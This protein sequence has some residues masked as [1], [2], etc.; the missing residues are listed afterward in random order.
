MEH[1]GRS[2]E[3]GTDAPMHEDDKIISAARV[4][5]R[6]NIRSVMLTVL[7]LLAII[8]TLYFARPLLM[9]IALAVLLSLVLMPVVRFL[10]RKLRLPDVVSSGLIVIGLAAVTIGG[11]YLLHRPAVNWLR[12]LP[13]GF[14]RMEDEIRELRR[15]VEELHQA[16]EQVDAAAN[17]SDGSALE[18]KV[19]QPGS[20]DMLIDGLQGL[21]IGG[22]MVG[23]YVFFLLASG[24]MFLLKLV[25]VIPKFEDKKLAVTIVHEIQED[26]ASYVF[27]ITLINIALGVTVGGVL[28]A[29]GVPNAGLWGVMATVLNYVPYLGAAVGVMVVGTVAMLRFDTVAEV[30]TPPICYLVLT[31]VEATFITPLILGKRLTL[32]PVVLF[33]CVVFWGWLWGIPGALIAVP[34]TVALAIMCTHIKQLQPVAEFISR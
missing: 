16:A 32:N 5:G 1:G 17:V 2:E 9:P 20:V 13:Q 29:L 23:A 30:L 28:Y 19:K 24:D 7:G 18:V 8:Y 3:A 26:I 12:E 14:A 15:P 33:T 6:V 11:V 21:V 22:F 4:T 31:S 27:T 25:R 34:C 10:R